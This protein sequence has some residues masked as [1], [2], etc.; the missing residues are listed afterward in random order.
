LKNRKAAEEKKRV[1]KHYLLEPILQEVGRARALPQLFIYLVKPEPWLKPDLS[2]T[3][4]VT[5]SNLKKSQTKVRSP[6][7]TRAKKSQA[8]PTSESYDRELQR[9]RC[10]NSQRHEYVHSLASYYFFKNALAHYNAGIVIVNS[11]VEGLHENL[12]IVILG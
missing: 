9:Q 12:S 7:A 8:R 5:L 4:L 11:E 10:K 2:L 6:I 3:Y 1:W